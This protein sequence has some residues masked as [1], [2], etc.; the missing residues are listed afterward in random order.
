ML[1]KLLVQHYVAFKET[2]R[3]LKIQKDARFNEA[4]IEAEIIRFVHSIEKGLSLQDPRLGFGFKKIQC[5]FDYIELYLKLEN[6][7]DYCLRMARGALNAYLK[8]H[9]EHSFSNENIIQIKNRARELLGNLEEDADYGGIL[10]LNNEQITCS[11]EHAK[12]LFETR[13]S[14]R[15]FSGEPVSEEDIRSAIEMAQYCPSA[16]NR[17]CARVY[18]ISSEKYMHDMDTNLQGIGG[19]ADDADKFL[20]VTAK[21]SAYEID[22]R[23]QFV[24]SASIFAGYLS[25]ALHACG[26]AS[27]AVQ[28]SL[29]LN[30]KWDKFREINGIP[31]DEQIVIMFAIGKYKSETK[32]PVSKRFSLSKIFRKL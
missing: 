24:V 13:H 4:R 21:M 23:N 20:L 6:S 1:K 15:E 32:V 31:D 8:F 11:R 3:N 22:E 14:V 27:C 18:S 9:E 5:L 10:T 28:R 7:D 26:I 30:E 17:Q 12:K 19:F 16:C 25:L 2:L 29:A